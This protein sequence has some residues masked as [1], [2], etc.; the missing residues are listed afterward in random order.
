MGYKGGEA[1]PWTVPPPIPNRKAEAKAGAKPGAKAKPA[2]K[3]DKGAK[4]KPG[5]GEP[6]HGM[7]GKVTVLEGER[8]EGSAEVPRLTVVDVSRMTEGQLERM[9]GLGSIRM[10]QEYGPTRDRYDRIGLGVPFPDDVAIA[11]LKRMRRT[12]AQVQACYYLVVH[13]VLQKGGDF[14]FEAPKK[15]QAPGA[16]GSP[17]APGEK[18]AP[19]FGK[20]AKLPFGQKD[21][22]TEEKE[23]E[24]KK[25]TAARPPFLESRE[26]P[27]KARAALERALALLDRPDAPDAQAEVLKL[28]DSAA[29][30]VG[31]DGASTGGTNG[32]NGTDGTEGPAP[33]EERAKAAN[34]EG[35][36]KPADGKPG[37]GE[38]PGP[39]QLK[40]KE[41]DEPGDEDAAEEGEEHLGPDG[42]PV[43]PAAEKGAKMVEFLRYVFN[44]QLQGGLM[45]MLREAMT[46]Y[47]AGFSVAEKVTA[48]I[49]EGPFKGKVGYRKVKFLDPERITFYQDFYGN[50][51]NIRVSSIG[52]V[53]G[54]VVSPWANYQVEVPTGLQ[55]VDAYGNPMFGVSKAAL[56]TINGEFGNAYGE[57]KFRPIYKYWKAKDF[58]LKMMMIYMERFA[59]PVRFGLVSN[60]SDEDKMLSILRSIHQ[61]RT[62]L[63]GIKDNMEIETLDTQQKEAM[64]EQAIKYM[65]LM[66]A[67][68]LLVPELLLSGGGASGGGSGSYA[69]G[70]QQSATFT[71]SV[72]EP[73]RRLLEEH[74]LKKQL[75][76][77]LIDANFGKQDVYPT[78]K[79]EKLSEKDLHTTASAVL[80]L[81]NGGIVGPDEQ[82][83]R[84]FLG[85]P[86]RDP[87]LG[88]I[89]PP[90]PP[91][92][93]PG[94]DG[95]PPGLEQPGQPG[96]RVGAAQPLPTGQRAPP[97]PEPGARGMQTRAAPRGAPG[98]PRVVKLRNISIPDCGV[99]QVWLVDERKV[100]DAI[101]VGFVYAS[102]GHLKQYIPQDE[103]WLGNSIP[104]ED[105][106]LILN[107]EMLEVYGL[108][109]KGM[110]I[111][112]AHAAAN[113]FEAQL[114]ARYK[115]DKE[116]GVMSVRQ[117]RQPRQRVQGP[118]RI[119]DN[120]QEHR[121]AID[122]WEAKFRATMTGA[123]AKY[124]EQ[125]VGSA[126]RLLRDRPKT[127]PV[128][129]AMPPRVTLAPAARTQDEVVTDKRAEVPN[130]PDA[131][132]SSSD[133]QADKDIIT[134]ALRE[135][136]QEELRY[137][138]DQSLARVREAGLATAGADAVAA[139]DQEWLEDLVDIVAEKAANDLRHQARLVVTNGLVN[140]QSDEEMLAELAEV[141]QDYIESQLPG[142]LRTNVMN[143]YTEGRRRVF[144]ATVGVVAFQYDATLDPV[145][146]DLC[147][148]LHGQVIAKGDPRLNLYSPPV[149]HECR[150]LLIP[151]TAFDG[152]S[153]D[154][155]PPDELVPWER[156]NYDNAEYAQRYRSSARAQ[157][158]RRRGR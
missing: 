131:R 40:P 32:T 55:A 28:L 115:Q 123:L 24:G 2:G 46:S 134:E 93:P 63:V 74:L 68:G 30:A 114:R 154:F 109:A 14:H 61:G 52:R 6:R 65:D 89:E 64:F 75:I 138:T 105:R 117:R 73:M 147:R 141:H 79:F 34:G 113:E 130:A 119:R 149:W 98:D 136:S 1:I 47:Y 87:G 12:D 86:E 116:Q 22:G 17:G 103:I 58:L 43:D 84:R 45:E 51:V 21:E 5:G 48:V 107:H 76:E 95:M 70:Y 83:I 42:L 132:A 126:R 146:T 26:A 41:K 10:D 148:E 77:P 15:P 129:M 82:W 19:P 62:D 156:P 44:E 53:G 94:L 38:P 49:E 106:E 137:V 31:A 128:P 155:D 27:D 72:I 39:F 66:I 88:P 25:E 91:Q 71:A 101:D 122:H 150:S 3:G 67:R 97:L 127:M 18:A 9:T 57:S 104:V 118:R 78:Y 92:F 20:K 11:E 16:P 60:P 135:L 125:L 144:D 120:P 7:K 124:H 151:V 81:I 56:L 145:T 111:E 158:S 29:E 152:L 4:A 90:P 69:L 13:S 108:V 102:H 139:E 142:V 110:P 50:L 133:L 37:E 140:Q 100:R 33:A 157:A 112:E 99:Y 8:P 23:P 85:I 96:Q 36:A 143:V 54:L 153:P 80:E 35:E 121:I 59:N